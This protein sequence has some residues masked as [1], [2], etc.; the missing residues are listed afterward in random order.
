MSEDP[1]QDPVFSPQDY[2]MAEL[3]VDSLLRD[4]EILFQVEGDSFDRET[5]QKHINERGVLIATKKLLLDQIERLI[6][7]QERS[8]E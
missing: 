1:K 4:R 6:K 8:A 7:S 2:L 3:V 5:M